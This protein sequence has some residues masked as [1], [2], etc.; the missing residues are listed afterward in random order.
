M[1]ESKRIICESEEYNDI[2]LKELEKSIRHSNRILFV[3][4]DT[5]KFGT[6]IN[7]VC[8]NNEYIKNSME[9]L[10]NGI[11][12]NEAIFKFKD[13]KQCVIK[14]ISTKGIKMTRGLK[15]NELFIIDT[16]LENEE[17][18]SYY[19]IYLLP[20]LISYSPN[21]KDITIKNIYID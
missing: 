16:D 19:E 7:G 9:H 3:C 18:K 17:F 13:D 12:V 6:I 8:K 4:K 21:H 20:C 14:C 2:V 1:F 5:E 10:Y 11:L 15:G